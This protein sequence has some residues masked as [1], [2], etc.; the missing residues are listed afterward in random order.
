M[1]TDPL[2]EGFFPSVLLI[3]RISLNQKDPKSFGFRGKKRGG[4]E[5][6]TAIFRNKSLRKA[7]WLFFP[8]C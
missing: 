6:T 8:S 1:C 3:M 5:I 4:G 2:N 7:F